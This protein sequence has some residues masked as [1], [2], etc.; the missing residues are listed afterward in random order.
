MAGSELLFFNIILLAPVVILGH[1][2]I[3]IDLEADHVALLLAVAI[4]L[5]EDVQQK[6][7]D[8]APDYKTIHIIS[9]AHAYR[10]TSRS[11]EERG[12]ASRIASPSLDSCDDALAGFT[13]FR[14][15]NFF[16]RSALK[17]S[18][19]ISAG[20][21]LLPELRFFSISLLLH[22]RLALTSAMI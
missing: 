18:L 8:F 22:F 2:I 16:L 6:H 19:L 1:V 7:Q 9:F 10:A 14:I 17:G 3:D 20:R 21:E 15:S 13:L 5:T 4:I 12:L 11:T